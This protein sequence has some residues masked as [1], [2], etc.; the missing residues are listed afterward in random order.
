VGVYHPQLDPIGGPMK[1]DQ[2]GADGGPT[3]Q[4]ELANALRKLG[5]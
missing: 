2:I 4:A 3:I 5:D 1:A